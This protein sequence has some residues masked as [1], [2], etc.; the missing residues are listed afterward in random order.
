MLNP[1]AILAQ[2]HTHQVPAAWRVHR[3]R[4]IFPLLALLR[5]IGFTLFGA[6][7]LSVAAFVGTIFVALGIDHRSPF[8]VFQQALPLVPAIIQGAIGSAA[9]VGLITFVRA[10]MT[11]PH[12][13]FIV[14]QEG[15]VQATSQ[16]SI[17]ALDFATI[18]RIDKQMQVKTFRSTNPTTGMPQN[19]T[20]IIWVAAIRYRDGSRTNWRPNW[21]FGSDQTF[22]DEIVGAFA[23]YAAN[24]SPLGHRS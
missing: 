10:S 1:P 15:V 24:V 23:Q 3:P 22:V 7:F 20:T 9:F 16:R 4:G 19:T 14:T 17:V 12:S 18:D 11:L 2:A 13:F 21:R 5:G 8:P 6:L